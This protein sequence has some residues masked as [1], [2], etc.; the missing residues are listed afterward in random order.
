MKKTTNFLYSGE[1][2]E[3]ELS[4]RNNGNVDAKNTYKNSEWRTPFLLAA[5]NGDSR[6]FYLNSCNEHMFKQIFSKFIYSGNQTVIESLLKNG[7]DVR[8]KSYKDYTPLIFAAQNGNH[9]QIESSE[10]NQNLC[11]G[12]FRSRR[13]S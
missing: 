8:S 3:V 13:N 11:I 12:I 7:A 5:K 6:K 9:F 2:K 10:L 1:N 4:N